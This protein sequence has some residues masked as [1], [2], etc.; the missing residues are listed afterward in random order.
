MK[1]SVV[2]D[3][4]LARSPRGSISASASLQRARRAFVRCVRTLTLSLLM[5]AGCAGAT[6]TPAPAPSPQ[7]CDLSAETRDLAAEFVRLRAVQGHFQG[8]PWIADVDD[9]L[10]KKHR[11]MIEL[12]SRLTGA[13]CR[14]A[15]VTELLG[16]PD[17]VARAGEAILDQVSRQ[18][19]FQAPP[20][21]RYEL[22]IYYWRAARDFLY[23]TSTTS[24]VGVAIAGSGWWHAYE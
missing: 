19:D 15:Q 10:G 3:Q 24:T 22:L 23:F 2:G 17:L 11:V 9:W 13:A 18:P 7:G 1:A 14:P 20:G 16:P 6:L 8:G 21:E 12:G 5:L 4:P